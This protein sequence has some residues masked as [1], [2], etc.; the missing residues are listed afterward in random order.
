MRCAEVNVPC[1][2]PS[3][4][5]NLFAKVAKKSD[6]LDNFLIDSRECTCSCAPFS[7]DSP[8]NWPSGSTFEKKRKKRRNKVR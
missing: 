7:F 8:R 5:N 6:K 1:L 4:R 3:Y 2:G